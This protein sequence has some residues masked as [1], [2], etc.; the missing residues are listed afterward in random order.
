LFLFAVRS[1]PRVTVVASGIAV[2]LSFAASRA[3]ATD[4]PA[5]E[6]VTVRGDRANAERERV[7]SEARFATSIDARD[8]GVRAGNVAELL[9]DAPGVH[10]RRTGDLLA[11]TTIAFRGAPT[12]HVTIALD[13]VVLNDAS[14]GGV[15][16]SL[17]S[18][19]LLERI[20]VYRGNAPVRL[21]MGGLAGAVEFITR[22]SSRALR[23]QIV[24]GVGSFLERRAYASL[25]GRLGLV[26]T[27]LSVGYRGTQ[28]NFT[29]YDDAGTPLF[30]NDDRPNAVR[31]NNAGNALDALARACIGPQ[32]ARSC[33]L[34]LFDWR[35]RGMPGPGSA[36]LDSP[37]LDQWRAVG[38]V[39]HRMVLERAW[40]EPYV[41]FTA[42][43]DHVLDRVGEIFVGEPIDAHTGGTAT[44]WGWTAMARRAD[45]RIEAIARQRF[46]TYS[47]GARS[48]GGLDANRNTLLAGADVRVD[49]GPLQV[50]G[51][52]A[53]EAMH[54]TRI[55]GAS[56]DRL[57]LSPRLGARVVLP[58]GFEARGNLTHLERSPTLVDLYGIAGYLLENPDLVP[59]RSDGA[60][61]GG[62]WNLHRDGWTIRA[63]LTSYGRRAHD[64]I[65]L[66][67]RGA[68][69]YKAFNLRDARI[70]GLESALRLAWR[71]YVE[72]VASHAFTNA[73]TIAPGTAIDGRTPPGI[74]EHDLYARAQGN[75]G[76]VSAWV[77]VSFVSGVYFDEFNGIA[78]PPRTLLGA[79]AQLRVPGVRGFAVSVTGSNLLD[80]RVAS[81]TVHQ[82][83]DY[84]IQ[85]PVQDFAGYPLPGRS[86][87]VTV[88]YAYES[89][90]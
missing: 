64:L 48:A 74:P 82:G 77:D 78:A 56:V 2:A 34:V 37:T 88:Q 87:F 51:T 23:A 80:Q 57:L 43:H 59:E 55:G 69:S 30:T 50:T 89:T 84:T 53:T 11:P 73:V 10:A 36:Q 68:V 46:E 20:D 52:L 35:L 85:Q 12:A 81:V 58:A 38:R 62:V 63:E 16:V 8:R 65:T 13:G 86:F 60:D 4:P 54:D 83:A 90:P 5:S 25:T 42:H 79:G 14:G 39:S 29:F 19:A 71:S 32:T 15:D 41:S 61:V 17:L 26:D 72:L 27:L 9:D 33:A 49:R 24:A 3:R 47:T 18:P 45:V 70:L 40:I 67:R 75:V 31:V 7:E 22:P 6:A 76:P 1:R 66:V 44:E 21:G 28:G